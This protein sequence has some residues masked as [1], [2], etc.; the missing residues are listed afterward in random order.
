MGSMSMPVPMRRT[1]QNAEGKLC[2][3]ENRMA[4]LT[5][6]LNLLTSTDRDARRQNRM[7]VAWTRISIPPGP[8]TVD[9]R[10]GK[11]LCTNRRTSDLGTV[12]RP[13]ERI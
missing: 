4:F 8:A 10:E 2:P 11:T 12:G 5:S 1:G 7:H 9:K 3:G 6:N 13:S